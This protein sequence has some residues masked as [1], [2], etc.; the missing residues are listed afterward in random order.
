MKLH[1]AAPA[2][3]GRMSAAW[4]NRIAARSRDDANVTGLT[5]DTVVMTR[6]GDVRAADLSP[7]DQIVTRGQGFAAAEAVERRRILTRA[8]RI[9]AGSL[10]DTRPD[11]SVIL[12]EAQKL[13]VRDWRSKALFGQPQALAAAGDLVDGEFILDLGEQLLELTVLRFARPVVLY[14]GGLE[15]AGATLRSADLRPAA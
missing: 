2:R 5:P 3:D 14:A 4:L 13:L 8:I 10:G 6:R 12:P 7:G 9:T 11:C 15:L 1:A